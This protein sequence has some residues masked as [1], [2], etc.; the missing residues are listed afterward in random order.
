MINNDF[1]YKYCNFKNILI[2][3]LFIGFSLIF[4]KIFLTIKNQNEK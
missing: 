3:I 4:F 2:L 1:F